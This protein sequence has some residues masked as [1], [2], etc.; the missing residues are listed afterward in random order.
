MAKRATHRRTKRQTKYRRSR[1]RTPR[2]GARM[3]GTQPTRRSARLATKKRLSM[4]GL[5][6]EIGS[7]EKKTVSTARKT[8]RKTTKRASKT[9]KKIKN[10]TVNELSSVL[11]AFK[12]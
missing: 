3:T 11:N 5:L 10:M 4:K 7:I 2:A 1:R 8:A 9:A 6:D 12:M